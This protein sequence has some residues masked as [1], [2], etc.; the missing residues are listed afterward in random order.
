MRRHAEPVIDLMPDQRGVVQQGRHDAPRGLPLR[1][2]ARA[3]SRAASTAA[4]EISERH[5]HRYEVNNELPRAL[6]EEQGLVM[7]GV[8]PEQAAWSR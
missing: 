2:Q 6:L 8:S 7:S 4:P 3:A 5:R 1:A